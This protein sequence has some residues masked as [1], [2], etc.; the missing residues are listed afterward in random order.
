MDQ[1]TSNVFWIFYVCWREGACASFFK[2]CDGLLLQG[3]RR[4][5]RRQINQ[6]NLASSVEG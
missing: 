1:S 3:F 6:T 2:A 4:S 5:V